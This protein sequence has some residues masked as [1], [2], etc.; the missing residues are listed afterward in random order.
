[1]KEIFSRIN[2]KE[3]I[4][5]LGI[6][7][8]LILVTSLPTLYGYLVKPADK[9]FP[10]LHSQGPG[11][12]NVYYSY[13][14]QVKQGHLL[15]SDLYTSE[16][17]QPF[18]FNPFWLIIGLFGRFFHLSN[19][20]TFQLA[21]I[22]FIFP[23]V[24]ALYLITS[25]FFN[26][27]RLRRYAFLF[28]IFASGF[29]GYS[30][31]IVKKIMGTGLNLHYYPMDLWVSEANN[32]LT[33]FHSP[34]F[35]AATTLII[36]VLLF[37]FLSFTKNNWRYTFWSGFLGLSLIF[38]HPFHLPNIFLV[39]LVYIVVVSLREKK[40]KWSYVFK[41]VAFVL[42]IMPAVIYQFMLV[43]Y[44]PIAAGRADQNIC[45]IVDWG[46]FLISYGFL[47]PLAFLG[48]FSRPK[49]E[50]YLFIFIW[51][52]VQLALIFSPLTFQRRLTQGW[53]IPLTFFSIWGLVMIFRKIGKKWPN[54]NFFANKIYIGVILAFCFCFSQ[55]YVLAENFS[56]YTDKIYREWP[57]YVYLDISYKQGFDWLKNNLT[58]NDVILSSTTTGSFI[59]AFSGLRIYIGHNM[60]TLKWSQKVY[61]VN[62]FFS[63]DLD[64]SQR[65]EFLEKK[66]ITYIYYSEFEKNLGDFRP[67]GKNYLESV[68]QK[69]ELII[70]RVISPF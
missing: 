57:H 63:L 7:I 8:I 10:A 43:I 39:P 37:L 44:N 50:K 3:W 24:F 54:I 60:E 36:F 65:R 29:G 42:L 41:L 12:Y 2:K 18:L 58:A 30:I 67:Q 52:F 70:Y 27:K 20:L 46:I 49:E 61:E 11:D 6:A 45:L 62:Q 26:E 64:D 68:F 21:R 25:Y 23:F 51:L 15:F 22:I 66:N 59:P 33:I 35:M 40:I 31:A 1:M 38:F 14:E 4:F 48:L 56:L 28:S 34:H 55:L 32:F 47:L 17:H 9:F 19:I 69:G 5:A 53:Q 13:I 16:S